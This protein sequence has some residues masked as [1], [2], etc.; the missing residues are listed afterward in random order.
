MKSNK[1]FYE[2]CT[3]FPKGKITAYKQHNNSCKCIPRNYLTRIIR[4]L[5]VQF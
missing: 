1:H 4:L 5:K 3:I 2:N